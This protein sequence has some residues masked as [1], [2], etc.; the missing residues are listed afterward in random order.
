MLR[1]FDIK[2][3]LRTVVKGLLADLVAKFTEDKLL[4]SPEEECDFN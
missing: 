3:Q 2:Y 1:A 4:E